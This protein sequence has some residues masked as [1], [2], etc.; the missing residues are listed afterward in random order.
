MKIETTDVRGKCRWCGCTEFRPCENTCAWA[1]RA[2][3]VCTECE[4]LDT[5]V[6]SAA[7][8]KKLAL[9]LQDEGRK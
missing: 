5:L 8:R 7:G 9:I 3:T 4:E 1:N 2:Q 6:R